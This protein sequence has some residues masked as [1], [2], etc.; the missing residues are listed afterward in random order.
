MS[1]MVPVFNFRPSK[2]DSE[3]VANLYT[4]KYEL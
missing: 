1:I 2:E 3:F 4:G